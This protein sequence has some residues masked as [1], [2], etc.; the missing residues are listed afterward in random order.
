MI[1]N[2]IWKSTF[3]EIRQSFGRFMAI[4]AIVAL[5]VAF[6][7][8]LK[9]AKSA[10]IK[11]AQQYLENTE[12]YD[13]RLVS[14]LGFEEE[15]VEF[16]ASQE[17]VRG[18]EG[19]V[20]WDVLYEIDEG[21]GGV[22]RAH[23]LTTKV[24]QVRVLYGRLP[25]RPEECVVDANLFGEEDLGRTIVLS[26]ENETEDL[27]AFS[28]QEYTIVGIAQS[29]YYLQYERGNTSLGSGLVNGFM[30]LMPE[31]FAM[32]YY[33][34]IFVKFQE[35]FA[36][37][38]DEYKTYI[39]E[40]EAVWEDLTVQAASRRFYNIQEEAA[41]ELADAR[42][43]LAEERADAEAELA[44]AEAELADAAAEIAAGEAE[45]A[46][47]R[48]EAAAAEETLDQEEARLADARQQIVDGEAE[49]AA[50][51]TELAD[52]I[53]EWSDR[54]KEAN[55]G[56]NQVKSAMD[57]LE[58][59]SARLDEQEARLLVGETALQQQ[60]AALDAQRQQTQTELQEAT[61]A[62]DEQ[63]AQLSAAYE[64]GTITEEAYEASLA[65][66]EAGRSELEQQRIQ[67]EET[68]GAA[69][70]GLDAYAQE[71]DSG[72]TALETG[73]RTIAAYQAQLNEAMAQV[74]AGE[75]QLAGAWMQIQDS[76]A[77]LERGKEEL[78]TA[79]TELADGEQQI[80][81]ARAELA[82]A[83]Q[84]IQDGEAELANGRQEYE[85][86]LSEYQNAR[87]EFETQMADADA[88]IADA[89]KEL[90]DMEKPETYVLGRDANIGY[91]CFENDSA[92]VD[93][94]ANIFPVFF[95]LVAALVCSTTMN[96]MVEEHRTQIGVL[97]ALGYQKGIIMS[98]YLIYSGTAAFAGGVLGF[99]GGSMLFPQV[100]WT[101]YG[102]MYRVDSLRYV[103][104]WRLA[105]VSLAAAL[106]C[107]M[108]TTWF[109][110]RYELSQVAAELMRPKA[111]KAGK[112]VFLEYVPF[113]WR[114]LGFLRKVSV[115][116]IFRYKKRL[117][118]MVT[119]ISGCTAL[120]VTG[121]GV[122][123][124]IANIAEQQ[125][126]EIQIYD[127]GISLSE[128]VTEQLQESISEAAGEVI[129]EYY[130][131]MESSMDLDFQQNSES[132]NLVAASDD[133][134][135]TSFLSLHTQDKEPLEY[136][137]EGQAVITCKVAQQLGISVGDTVTLQDG[138]GG[139]IVL[140]VSGI[141]RNFI[142]D[143]V[144]I[145]AADYENQIGEPAQYKTLWVNVVPEEDIHL[146]SAA[147]M[148]VDG[149]SNVT[150]NQDTMD[151]FSSMMDSLNIIVVVII[152]CAGGL[153]FIVLYNLTNINITERV[154]EIATIKV[155]GFYKKET[156]AYVFRENTVLAMM[157]AAVGLPLG[158]FLHRFVMAQ[159]QIDMVS[160]DVKIRPES[161][162]Y[163]AALTLLFAWLINRF[164]RR[165]LAQVSMTESLKSVD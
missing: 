130:P 14:T 71:L 143:Y 42:R 32:D 97:K 123:D 4:L 148:Q 70:S 118:M 63:E 149:V 12:F 38:S 6:F 41:A 101:A 128:N 122:K 76:Q 57:E 93:G 126:G 43:K 160:F 26:S 40:R 9:V 21:S 44:D 56:Y 61:A 155:L 98:K 110:C 137:K 165:K 108:G 17:E 136:P 19:S 150:I 58:Q 115:R 31:G 66:I 72:R 35:D 53:D 102:I 7:S 3:R 85:D 144:Y 45:L 127:A 84:E 81:D 163:S 68:F 69:Q 25:E 138:D 46:D 157:G 36:L 94:I 34:E 5:G 134:D 116:N 91:V 51:E 131:V 23:T 164:M 152:I 146:M 106:L 33:T 59:Q 47:A 114:R 159:V 89:Q 39:E 29:P 75:R 120:L 139:S 153:A 135:I 145:N 125:F 86:G 77:E 99:F 30:Y 119:G 50:G 162:L 67:A 49:I 2:T 105:A 133:M 92:I 78:E 1:R 117:F 129:E 147:I 82:D 104:D 121:F 103:F 113:I 96:R 109:T 20:T 28:Y 65:A 111:P 124:S 141:C 8:G 15:D 10:M 27:D 13:F 112:R 100:I 90:D 79:R 142:Y 87:E 132:I 55:D 151:R 22:I 52:A 11:T 64:A 107:T 140:E 74:E 24:N 37:Y 18:A 158:Y 60:Q 80:A 62:L 161:Y 48:K 16:F 88:E 95:F 154:R 54:S 83:K 156:S 73:R